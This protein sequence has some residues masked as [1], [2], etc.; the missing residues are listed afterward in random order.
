MDLHVEGLIDHVWKLV[1]Y[2]IAG[3]VHG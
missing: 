3:Q 1:R 2:D